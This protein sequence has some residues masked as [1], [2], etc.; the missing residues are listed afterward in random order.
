[1]PIVDNTQ[2]HP[3]PSPQ[4]LRSSSENGIELAPGIRVGPDT[5]RTQFSRSGGPGGQNVNKLNTKA[6][7]WLPLE[8]LTDLPPRALTRLRAAAGRRITKA[9]EL[10]LSSEAERTAEA[11]RN[12]VM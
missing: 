3:A 11:N 10:H 6:E 2:D 7:L 12:A 5:L 1:N 4:S 9:G 8:H